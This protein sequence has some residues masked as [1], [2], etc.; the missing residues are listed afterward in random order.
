MTKKTRII[1]LFF[2]VVC[3][4]GGALIII[5]YSMGYRF[6]FEKM[7]IIKTGGIY[8][9]TF[10][11][12]EEV[13]VDSKIFGKS[14]LFSNDILFQSLLPGEHNVLIKKENY[15]DYYKNIEVEEGLVTKLEE[16][17]LF[18]KNITY[19]TLPTNN[20]NETATPFNK[21]EKF[22]I[23]NNNL[24]YSN[25]KENIN[26][27]KTQKTVPVLKKILNFTT[28][29]NN[30]IWLNTDGFLYSSDQS[31]LL[32]EPTK[33]TENPIKIVKGGLYK[34]VLDN[35]NIFI[36]NN[37]KLL[38]L[39]KE[40]KILEDFFAKT[41]GAKIS[42]NSKI[43]AHWNNGN[44][45]VSNIIKQPTAYLLFQSELKITDLFW[46]N[47]YY[48]AFTAG[49][50][51]MISEIDYRGNVNVIEL[52]QT[53]IIPANPD[54][55]NSKEQTITIKSPR[56]YYNSQENKLYILTGK[57]LLISEKLIP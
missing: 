12:F 27:T 44:L 30:I 47:N 43:I 33:L 51:I 3:F 22:I 15:Y 24:Y 52:P 57:T 48:V 1:I 49:D 6:D 21:E 25:A 39:N 7:R 29:N 40:T 32:A 19:T 56:I 53:A 28:Q 41:S 50:K 35:Q 17:N 5:P 31:N 10:P 20:D 13:L 45:Y 11:S 26:L 36:N 42:P 2:C 55:V 37:G 23:K 54:E 9:R 34:I 18:K 4:L 14:K 46:I 16:V 8:V 38:I